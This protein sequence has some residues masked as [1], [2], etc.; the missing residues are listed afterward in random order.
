[1]CVREEVGGR[2]KERERDRETEEGQVEWGKKSLCSKSI[3]MNSLCWI[4][5]QIP[6]IDEMP[7]H[8]IPSTNILS[9]PR[10]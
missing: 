8:K 6:M 4:L 5:L 3:R 10:S 7:S 9:I 2:E 1:M